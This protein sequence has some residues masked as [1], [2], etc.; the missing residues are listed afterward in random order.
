M[1]SDSSSTLGSKPSSGLGDDAVSDK[2]KG[3]QPAAKQAMD[4]YFSD[5]FADM[6]GAAVSD[7]SE[8]RE[9]LGTAHTSESPLIPESTKHSESQQPESTQHSEPPKVS[10]FVDPEA[11]KARL[12]KARALRAPQHSEQTPSGESLK[13]D[14][15][16]QYDSQAHSSELANEVSEAGQLAEKHVPVQKEPNQ[17]APN[18]DTDSRQQGSTSEHQEQLPSKLADLRHAEPSLKAKKVT[19][20]ADPRKLPEAP[21]AKL[22]TLAP[23]KLKAATQEKTATQ[24]KVETSIRTEPK[25]EL[26]TKVQSEVKTERNTKVNTKVSTKVSSQ[27]NTKVK[28]P[29]VAQTIEKAST[30][31]AVVEDQLVAQTHKLESEQQTAQKSVERAAHEWLENGRP[32]WAQERFECLL[33]SV[34]GLKLA[35]PLVS[36]GS[37]HKIEKDFTPLVGRADW[38]LGLYRTGGRN[39]RVVDSAKWVMPQRHVPEVIDGYEYI[40]RLADSAWGMACDSVAQAIQL[41]PEQVKWRTERSKR[42]WLSGTV[43]DHMCALLDADTLAHLLKQD[44]LSHRK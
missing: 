5:M 19:V 40:I 33:F 21:P 4:D 37:I 29:V 16:Q 7:V 26:K 13:S 32:A 15:K 14:A 35:V 2:Q 34:A 9:T 22:P 24:V 39:I 20:F 38:F 8:T 36:L 11:V 44:A 43:I 10:V 31:T 12:A 28:T 23:P 6:G 18:F 25:T 17:F 30:K 3:A 27:V 41:E 42:A 1:A